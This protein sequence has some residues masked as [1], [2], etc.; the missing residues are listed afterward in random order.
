MPFFFSPRDKLK[1]KSI[2]NQWDVQG[3]APAKKADWLLEGHLT[4]FSKTE[5]EVGFPPDWHRAVVSGIQG[6]LS[7]VGQGAEGFG[8]LGK[9]AD[10]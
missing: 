3:A 8:D 10:L 4:Y 6:V 1:Y 2:L 9:G 5:K 7:L